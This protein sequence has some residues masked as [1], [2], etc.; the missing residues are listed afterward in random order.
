M[1]PLIK[2]ILLNIIIIKI[3]FLENKCNKN[4][5]Y[6][7]LNK[8]H[9][10]INNFTLISKKLS[11]NFQIPYGL[12]KNSIKSLFIRLLIHSYNSL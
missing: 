5:K 1:K 2:K 9:K 11:K 6:I 3:N 12:T 8:S 7:D 10:I 4:Q